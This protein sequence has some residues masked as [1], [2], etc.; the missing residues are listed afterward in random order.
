M[1]QFHKLLR[2]KFLG[3]CYYCVAGIPQVAD[4]TAHLNHAKKA[5]EFGY[6]MITIIQY[7]R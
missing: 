6:D 3:D 7:V 2:I 1:F 5:V 4:S